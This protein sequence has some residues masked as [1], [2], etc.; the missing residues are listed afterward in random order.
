MLEDTLRQVSA[1]LLRGQ[2]VPAALRVIWQE[3]LQ[4]DK[5][6]FTVSDPEKGGWPEIGLFTDNDADW[7]FGDPDESPFHRACMAFLREWSIV[8]G[9]ADSGLFG[10]WFYRPDLSVEQAAIVYFDSEANFFTTAPSL[11][12]HFLRKHPWWGHDDDDDETRAVR[13]WFSDRGIPTSSS[14][15]AIREAA[16][17]LPQ[18]AGRLHELIDSFKA[19][20]S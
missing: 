10:Y 2:P 12:D 20:S 11:Q 19:Q 3:Y 7:Y 16:E 17:A 1:K 8:G 18:P 15:R 13:K 14:R 5:T 4:I 6:G 9:D